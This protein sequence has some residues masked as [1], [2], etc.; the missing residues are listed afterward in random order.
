MVSYAQ[1][2]ILK[3]FMPGAIMP[4]IFVNQIGVDYLL[5]KKKALKLFLQATKNLRKLNENQC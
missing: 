3:A 2:N 4:G 5:I 1:G